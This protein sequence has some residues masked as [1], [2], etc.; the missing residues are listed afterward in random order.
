MEMA[1]QNNF[2]TNSNE[3]YVK[4][5]GLA[6]A[7]VCNDVNI[8]RLEQDSSGFFWF[9]FPTGKSNEIS[10]AYWADELI[11]KAKKYRESTKALQARLNAQRGAY[12]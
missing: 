6:S 11:V 5:L 2:N 4:D 7:I 3:F 10:D 12:Q 8:L 1:I 9:I